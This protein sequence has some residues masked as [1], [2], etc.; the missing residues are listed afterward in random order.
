MHDWWLALCAG[1]FGRLEFIPEKLV[2]Y[3]QH[4]DNAIGAKSFWHGLN[5]FTNW[6]AGWRRG[7]AEFLATVR[8][9]R[10]F[11]RAMA[12]RLEQD[13]ETLDMLELYGGLDL[14]DR[15]SRLSVLR[16]CGLWRNH[17]FLNIML[18]LRMV[19]LPRKPA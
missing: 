1:F 9:A 15:R 18:I 3:R 7:D 10:A 4:G 8:Q 13:R 2:R 12:G 14:A 17:W 16:Q 19:L 11:H 6:Y 5:P